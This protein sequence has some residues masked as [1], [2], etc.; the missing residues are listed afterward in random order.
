[1]TA[2]SETLAEAAALFNDV[3]TADAE[4]LF[5]EVLLISPRNPDALHLLGLVAQRTGRHRHAVEWIHEAIAE[6]PSHAPFHADLAESYRALDRPSDAEAACRRALALDPDYA[7]AHHRLGLALW[8]QGRIEET[9]AAIERSVACDD[10]VAIY[11]NTL[12]TVLSQTGDAERAADS[13]R[14]A[15]T[16]DPGYA[17]AR[18]NLAAAIEG[19]GD[20][21]NA[22][23]HLSEAVRLDPG[24]APA[25]ARLGA[26]LLRIGR[27]EDSL[28][29]Y[30]AGLETAPNNPDLLNGHG[31]ALLAAEHPAAAAEAFAS[32]VKKQP[33]A[34]AARLNLATALLRQGRVE[35]AR[36]A[37]RDAHRE[38][39]SD[40]RIH[41]TLLHIGQ[42][43]DAEDRESSL[44]AHRNWAHR[45][46]APLAPEIKP[47]QNDRDPERPLVVGYVSPD[48]RRH[49][50]ASFVR[51]LLQHHDRSRYRLH[52]Y[53]G[54]QA[55]DED[56]AWFRDQVDLWRPTD[57]LSD[58]ELADLIRGDK[59]DILVDLAGHTAGNRLPAFARRPAPVQISYLGYPD[60]SGTVAIDA[61]LTDAV[62]EP[63]GNERWSVESL[64]RLRDG[65]LCFD[66]GECPNVR[67]LPAGPDKPLTFGCFA[68]LWKINASHAKTWSEI[69]RA[70]PHAR[71]IVKAF[72]LSEHAVRANVSS[73]FRDAGIA[74]DKIELRPLAPDR[75]AHLAQ[76]NDVD[77]AL[78][79]YPYNGVAT[80]CESLWMGVPMVTLAG[81][82]PASRSGAS[83]M[84]RIGLDLLVAADAAAYVKI[85]TALARD[86]KRLASLR[87]D[88]RGRMRDSP[89]TDGPNF[90][91]GVEEAYR[92]TWR[93]WT[94]AFAA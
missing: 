90:A 20:I 68:N 66:P 50:I 35:E 43:L 9:R 58:A 24:F 17:I 45:H 44:A 82:A 67:P 1:M 57:G 42:Y 47:Y 62:L 69:L 10:G 5:R 21:E 86:R 4:A 89:L 27:I 80:T 53:A 64:I 77:I 81:R 7:A 29:A 84:R 85:A 88:L 61:R 38:H 83:I 23:R 39:P 25:H 74:A 54:G 13:F 6:S 55:E 75:E 70:V 12:G 22:L 73:M 93:R 94:R 2:V 34:G 36:E 33:G 41:S 26:L 11:H 71:L 14:R 30:A 78:D 76:Y 87:R 49:A 92:A 72:A 32:L 3:R 63:E 18:V 15:V 60:T 31:L 91:R 40:A 28:S 52:A 19:L 51:P 46:A 48:L 56:R 16:L 37:A 8:A 59:V 79:T 65:A